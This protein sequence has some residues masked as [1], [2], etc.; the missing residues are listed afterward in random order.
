MDPLRTYDYLLR[1]RRRVLDAVRP[2][3]PQAYL[4]PFP[5]GLRSIGSTLTHIMI[6]E[7]YY[8]ERLLGRDVPP[9]DTWPIKYESPPPFDTVEATWREQADRTRATLAAER[10]WN[11]PISY[12]SFPDDAGRRYHIRTTAGDFFAQ[13]ALHEVHHRAQVLVMLR[14]LA[15]EPG[16]ACKPLTGE[17][18]DYNVLMFDRQLAS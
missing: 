12:L 17:E 8:V 16:S 6:S 9:Y 14:L 13:L 2:I 11:R 7:W 1:A 10:D 4:R 15:A 3:S 18:I 5:F